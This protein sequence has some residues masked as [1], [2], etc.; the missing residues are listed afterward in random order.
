LF[1]FLGTLLL[2]VVP[3]ALWPRGAEDFGYFAFGLGCAMMGGVCFGGEFQRRTL[4]LLLSQPVARGVIW[5]E[6]MWVL[7]T[8]MAVNLAVCWL[9]LAIFCPHSVMW[10]AL[11]AIAVCIFCGAP[12][13]TLQ[14]RHTLAGTMTALGA[15][16]TLLMLGALVVAAGSRWLSKPFFENPRLLT[17]GTTLLL[18]SYS[19][20]AYRQGHARFQQLELVE[21]ASLEPKLPA[22]AEAALARLLGGISAQFTGPFASLVKKELR[23][24]R[25]SYIGAVCFCLLAVAGALIH[26][27]APEWG[28]GILAADYSIYLLLI[29]FVVGA[30][31]VAEE[32]GWGLAEWHLTLPPPA[33]KQWL[34][35]MAAVLF[36]AV[37][38]GLLLPAAMIC[39][40]LGELRGEPVLALALA[41]QL[42]LVSLAAY[43]ASFCRTTMYAILLALGL[44]VATATAC[45]WAVHFASDHWWPMSLSNA[46]PPAKTGLWAFGIGITCLAALVQRFAYANFRQSGSSARRCL[47]QVLLLLVLSG[48]L[49]AAILPLF[50]VPTF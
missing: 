1:P 9:C 30:M 7:A 34:V 36:T 41:V 29:P 48:A 11:I 32:R 3:Y 26:L 24:Q 13:W 16:G 35:K 12:A 8:A 43:A 18:S 33:V 42:W 5:R 50:A 44:V 4:S 38:L 39:A 49:A 2:I 6:K 21:T 23:L 17:F 15:P 25:F 47:I 27:W 10:W 14:S 22:W 31:S 40:T 37:F 45:G 46:I 28:A 20:W 19:I